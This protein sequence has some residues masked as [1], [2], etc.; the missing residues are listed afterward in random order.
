MRIRFAIFFV[1]LAAFFSFVYAGEPAPSGKGQEGWKK[2]IWV[3]EKGVKHVTLV[4]VPTRKTEA[5]ART[6]PA[7]RE[8]LPEI[9]TAKVARAKGVDSIE[10]EDGKLVR[11]IG[12]QGP[13][14]TEPAYKEAVAFH[15]KIIEGK[16][17][18]I[19][20]G[21]EPRARDGSLWGFVFVNKLTFVNA[22]LV[23]FGYAYAN[24]I[25]PNTEYRV[26]FDILQNR[27]STRK[28]G[29]WNKSTP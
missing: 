12:V 20:P 22:E 14:S 18:N 4:S 23:R 3:D 16:W 19:L 29:L 24:P 21:V 5:P 6:A 1:L 11:Y 27:A 25:E 9:I 13:P 28:L 26:L 2:I 15:R 10:L 8:P 17:V 7:V